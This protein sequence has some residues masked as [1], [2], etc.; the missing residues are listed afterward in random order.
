M[1]IWSLH[2]KAI[3]G[4]LRGKTLPQGA[5]LTVLQRTNLLPPFASQNMVGDLLR[6]VALGQTD[7]YLSFVTE[8]GEHRQ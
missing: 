3:L 1:Q 7:P 8:P 4:S 5:S 2:S 6:E